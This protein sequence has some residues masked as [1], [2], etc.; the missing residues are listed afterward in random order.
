MKRLAT[1]FETKQTLDP[2]CWVSAFLPKS[3]RPV[4]VLASKEITVLNQEDMKDLL[5]NNML[6]PSDRL[7][8]ETVLGHLWNK[9]QEPYKHW[10]D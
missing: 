6:L 3:N 4:A 1:V 2:I 9:N 5:R 10:N 8:L 7:M